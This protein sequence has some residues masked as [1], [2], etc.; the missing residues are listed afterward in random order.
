MKKVLYFVGQALP[1]IVKN[2][3]INISLRGWPATVAILG[4]CGSGVAI[5]YIS[6]THDGPADDEAL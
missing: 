2:V 6:V 3:H 1:E 5:Y 4:V